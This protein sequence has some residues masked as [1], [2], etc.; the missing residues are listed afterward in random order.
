[1]YYKKRAG[2]L[3]AGFSL[4]IVLLLALIY[5]SCSQSRIERTTIPTSQIKKINHNEDFPF[6]KLH[7][8][9]GEAYILSNWEVENKNK[10]IKGNGK[11]LDI[12]RTVIDSGD[13]S[14]NYNDVAL[15]ET[16]KIN[17][18]S[19]LTALSFMTG[20]SL[21]I[22]G[23]CI[24]NPKA[25]FGSCPTFYICDSNDYKLRAEGFSSSV[26]PSLEDY[27]IDAL[28]NFK[29]ESN[30]LDV[31][32]RNEA[33]ET[34]A[35]RHINILALPRGEK[36]RVLV[37]PGGKFFETC[38]ITGLKSAIAE[39]G[40]CTQKF[41]YFDGNEWFSQADSNNLAENETIELEFEKSAISN[42]GLII[43]CRQT[44]L[45]TF[46]FYQTLAYM[47]KNAG[48][49]IS[50]LERNGSDL[51]N[52]VGYPGKL[53]KNIEILQQ[54]SSGEWIKIDLTGE[55]GPI[56]ADI[57]IVPLRNINDTKELKLRLK[58]TRG[59]WRIDYAALAD[60]GEEVFPLVI[61][62]SGTLPEKVNGSNVEGLLLNEDSL[63]VTLPGDKYNIY[64]ELPD[65]YSSYEYFIE[66]KGYYLEWI[67][68][69]WLAEEN[70]SMVA[71]MIFNA[72]QYFKDLAPQYK[73]IESEM[74]GAFWRSKYV[75]P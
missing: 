72:N 53:L 59:M 9:D 70:S 69:V 23:L 57:K 14:I 74:E 15:V 7:M 63:L 75:N 10:L 28:Y 47:G 45:S 64:Y 17:S 39:E 34:H 37:T 6:I 25:C 66:S 54:N 2:E 8:R 30:I 68:D 16:N 65:N 51:K 13:F 12:N 26:A 42:K 52:F 55:T 20:V 36:K 18:S 11:H 40:E 62:P 60:I 31:Q 21:A 5:L 58:M 24:A 27:D 32:V 3:K 49:Y 43:A 19:S 46:L 48:F 41:Q 4:I 73:R 56:A 61:K 35:I 67:R 71:E 22:T 1:M 38:N 33:L 44:L 50:Q 29:P